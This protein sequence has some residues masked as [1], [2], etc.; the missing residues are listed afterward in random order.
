M[1]EKRV[2][3]N[4]NTTKEFLDEKGIT[5]E[6]VKDNLKFLSSIFGLNYLKLFPLE[7]ST[8]DIE[9]VYYCSEILRSIQECDGFNRHIKEYN[10]NNIGAH[11]YTARVAKFLLNRGYKIILEP[12]MGKKDGPHPDIK[13]E[14]A[15]KICFVECKTS[16]ISNYFKR[17]LKKKVAD[18]VYEKISTPDQID[19]FFKSPITREE[20]QELL[21]DDIVVKQ[22][23]LCY[24]RGKDGKETRFKINENLEINVIQRPAIIGNE[25]SFLEVTMEM[26]MEDISSG[27][28]SI[29]YAFSKGGRSIGVY[30]VVDYSNKLKDKKEQSE[31]Q[32]IS[33]F[34]N[35]VFI[36]D[37]DVVGDPILHKQYIDDEWLTIDLADCSGVVVFDN[38]NSP[39]QPGENEKFKYY[40]N[41]NASNDF[42]I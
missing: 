16:N 28:R 8:N 23:Y 40:K 17:A 32:L 31:K 4:I 2:S 39:L 1:K 13:I 26:Y 37:A 41:S 18:L 33:S 3:F 14:K 29:G 30:D 35:V 27:T 11:L 5:I 22:V 12:D 42:D 19:L 15:E 24:E 9:Y 36:R 7:I 21:K 25:R 6:N 38:Y 10:S 34:P 20:I